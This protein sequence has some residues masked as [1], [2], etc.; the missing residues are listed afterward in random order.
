MFDNGLEFV[1]Y[2]T[3]GTIKE[4]IE[5]N[6]TNNTFRVNIIGEPSMNDWGNTRRPQVVIKKIEIL[7]KETNDFDDDLYYF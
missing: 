2:G 3:R 4:E 5:S 6:L 7:P 1:S